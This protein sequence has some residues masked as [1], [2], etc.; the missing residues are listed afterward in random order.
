MTLSQIS[1]KCVILSFFIIQVVLFSPF[2][3]VF[4]W[5]FMAGRVDHLRFRDA[6]PLVIISNQKGV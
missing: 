1:E 2:L 6:L 4:S 3:C 5:N